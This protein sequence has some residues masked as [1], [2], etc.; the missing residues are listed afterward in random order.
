MGRRGRELRID[1]TIASWYDPSLPITGS[2]WDAL[3]A[4]LLLLPPS[5]RRSVLVLGL[6]GGS[7]ARVMRALAPGARIVGIEK[8]REVLD[9]ARRW[10]D[11]DSLG[12]EVVVGDARSWLARTRRRFDVVIEDIFV[13]RGRAVHKPDWLPAPGLELAA[14]RLRPGG[15]LVSNTI[16]ESAAV[17]REL[18]RLFPHAVGIEVED[19][20]NRVLVAARTKLSG[21]ALRDA[22]RAEPVFAATLPRLR[23][24]TLA[25]AERRSR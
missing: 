20:D 9:A 3:A 5:R 21:Q 13:G 23:F 1:G 15:L 24:R 25:R 8:S 14:R 7:V 18:R 19:F 17:A 6:G 16:D 2:V 22:V 4:P 12:V 11:L 10:L